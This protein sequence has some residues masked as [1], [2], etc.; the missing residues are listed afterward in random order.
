MDSVPPPSEEGRDRPLSFLA[1]AGWTLLSFLLVMIAMGVTESAHPGAFYDL[2]TRTL[3][4]ALSYSL[5]LFAILRVHEPETSIR[6]VLA[7]RSPSPV[8]TFLAV[9]VGAG[10]ALPGAWLDS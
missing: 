10:L 3:C 1:A 7:L 4:F 5:V 6:Q 8:A 2:V 9:L